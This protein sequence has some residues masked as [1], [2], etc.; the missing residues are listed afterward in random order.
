M[1][2]LPTTARPDLSTTSVTP[3]EDCPPDGLFEPLNG[4]NQPLL[5]LRAG[6]PLTDA[7]SKQLIDSMQRSLHQIQYAAEALAQVLPAFDPAPAASL[8]S[9]CGGLIGPDEEP[10]PVEDDTV[11]AAC[12]AAWPR[13][14]LHMG[15]FLGVP[16]AR[17]AALLPV[18]L[19]GGWTETFCEACGHEVG[20]LDMDQCART[21]P[22]HRPRHPGP[23]ALRR[24]GFVYDWSEARGAYIAR[25]GAAL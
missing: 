6:K 21:G 17:V 14:D 13:T 2:D 10:A 7:E 8:C 12:F 1:T 11:C 3:R 18:P 19:D 20:S 15:A 9:A 5:K 4:A 24:H 22:C 23:M 25:D 16:Q